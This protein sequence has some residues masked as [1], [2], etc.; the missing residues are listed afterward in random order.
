MGG[1]CAEWLWADPT[2]WCLRL[3]MWGPG[4][5]RVRK[6]RKRTLAPLPDLQALEGC[7]CSVGLVPA[8]PGP[9]LRLPPGGGR[10]HCR[11]LWRGCP[12][13]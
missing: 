3:R 2:I 8:P 9:T 4:L 11:C 6:R 13:P 5:D 12:V 1:L 10:R 7:G